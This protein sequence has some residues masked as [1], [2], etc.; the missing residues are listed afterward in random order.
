MI[1]LSDLNERQRE[2]V[3]CTEGPV[4]VL[5]GAG[6]GKTRMLVSKMAHLLEEQK[7]S[8]FE[9]LALTFSN[10]AAREMQTR[11][12]RL[13]GDCAKALRV[14]TF[15]GFCARTLRAEATYLGLAPSFT[16]YDSS[17]SKA[18]I[19]AV[20]KKMDMRKL[21]P[22]EILSFIN[23][24]K[25]SG[26]Y[27]GKEIH[28][29]DDFL[30]TLYQYYESE[31]LR[32]NAVDFG[33]LLTGVLKLFETFPEVLKRY[34]NRCRYIL[35]DE[36]QDTNKAQ[37]DLI[38]LMAQGHQ[39]ICVVGDDDQSIY[40]WRGADINNILDFKKFFPGA[41][42]IKLEQNYRSGRVIIDAA[43]EVIAH[44]TMRSSKTMWTE[45]G[46]GE[47]IEITECQTD[48][49]EATWV[50]QKIEQ[51]KNDGTDGWEIGVFYRTNAQSRMLEDALR[52]RQIPYHVVGGLK[53][54]DRKEIKDLVAYLR[55]TVNKK[56]NLAFSRIIN[57]PSRG[58]GAITLRKLEQSALEYGTSL[59]GISEL[60]FKG[61]VSV[62][63]GV[64]Q[65]NALCQF[66]S[67]I[68]GVCELGEAGVSPSS[69]YQK[70]FEE[71]GLRLQLENAKDYESISRLENL[72]ELGHAIVQYEEAATA[73]TLAGFLETL[74]LDGGAEA[75]TSGG[76]VALMTV[77]GAKGLE[78]SH[79]FVTGIEEN[80]FPS[81][82][83]LSMGTTAVEE[84]RRLFYVAMTRAMERLYLTFA[85]GRMLFGQ[86]RF[87]G[88][89]RFL[90]EVPK[91]YRNWNK[92]NQD[93][94]VDESAL[95][96]MGTHVYHSLYGEGIVLE[97]RGSGEEERATIRF[98]DGIRRKF[99]VQDA[100]LAP[101]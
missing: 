55:L 2:A 23:Q 45:R 51:L 86:V 97:S 71:S 60:I 11:A 27:E 31:L 24:V 74:T 39:R 78:F 72:E 67:L 18:V 76:G 15:H 65:K 42:T 98:S 56:D 64:A 14:F 10:K 28:V 54:Y 40:S 48:K 34:Q 5:A 91:E 9:L 96:G 77:H 6:S 37:F 99:R 8:P 79:V 59:F 88:P 4:M 20:L 73:P 32:A 83:S 22:Y 66:V 92:M 12:I 95:Y 63:L 44:N 25:N 68:N 70:I 47:R 49:E 35:V 87:N 36:Y 81:Y 90:C 82:Q 85:Q 52:M 21:N 16:I 30:Y 100:P 75:D 26:H 7:V 101:L 29:K 53:F 80:V 94:F 1:D 84:E 33:G 38:R 19:K 43:A 61:G 46:E 69:L 93:Y 58:I 13:A 62:N 57:T 17:E 3:L 89:S 50:A 41:K